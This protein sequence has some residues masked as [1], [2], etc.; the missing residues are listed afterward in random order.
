MSGGPGIVKDKLVS[1]R[2]S[3]IRHRQFRWLVVVLRSNGH[4]DGPSHADHVAPRR[5]AVSPLATEPVRLAANCSNRRET[6]M[7]GQKYPIAP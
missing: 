3:G 4:T 2:P 7:K 6:W 1:R 5:P